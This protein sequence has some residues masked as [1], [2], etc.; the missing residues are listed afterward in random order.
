MEDGKVNFFMALGGNFLSAS[1]DTKRTSE[2][3]ENC[4]MTVQIST[5]LNRSHCIVGKKA[6][7]LPCLVRSEK[8]LKKNHRF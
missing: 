3:L 4:S 1:P 6:L 8:D 2:A 5:K 7:I